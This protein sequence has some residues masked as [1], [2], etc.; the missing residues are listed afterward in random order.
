MRVRLLFVALMLASCSKEEAKQKFEDAK[1][2]AG[3]LASV[4]GEKAKEGASIAKDAALAAKDKTVE[5]AA[6]AGE[7]AGELAGEAKD[8]AV[9]AG[10][11]AGELTSVAKD[12]AAL[13]LSGAKSSVDVVSSIKSEF[14][15]DYQ[16]VNNYDLEVSSEGIDDAGM[17]AL[18]AQVATLPNVTVGGVKVA[19]EDRSSTT[20]HNVTYAKSFGAVWTVAGKKIGLTFY[21]QQNIDTMAFAD[22][23]QKLVPLVEKYVK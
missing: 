16:T 14:D 17:K 8:A 23:L 20:I 11:K 22:A 7:K 18:E 15:K 4:A 2:Q 10:A 13:F 9:A 21:T 1:N 19:Y 5:V 3:A 6:A 12:S